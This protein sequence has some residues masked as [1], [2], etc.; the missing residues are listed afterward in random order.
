MLC[1]GCGK[2]DA[3]APAGDSAGVIR[4]EPI[5]AVSRTGGPP[6]W[7][8]PTTNLP[9]VVEHGF[10]RVGFDRLSSFKYEVYEYYSETHS[11]RPFL[12]SDDTIPAVVRAYDGKRVSVRGFVLALRTKR[13]KTI[14]F[15]LLRDQ[16]TCCF[17][18]QAQINH[19]I[20]VRHPAGAEFEQ[21]REYKVSGTLQVGEV[22]VQ[23]YLTGIYKLE[24]DTVE[25]AGP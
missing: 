24:A 12:K 4:G 22:Y 6:R 5:A 14:E 16:G 17:G 21:G 15:L 7:I 2:P 19:F 11:G 18:P 10:L 9:E 3:S 1:A 25:L 20:R 23:G 8:A 13:A